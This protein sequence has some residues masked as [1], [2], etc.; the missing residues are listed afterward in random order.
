MKD[1][2]ITN[3]KLV[4]LARILIILVIV[5]IVAD[6][7]GIK[8]SRFLRSNIGMR[9]VTQPAGDLGA[10]ER[11][12]MEVFE[13]V[14]PSVTYITNK[15]FQRDYFSFNVMEIPQGTGSGFLWDDKGHIVTNFHVIYEA[16]EIEVRLQNGKSYDA[17]IVGADPDHDLAVL[18]IN[19]TNLNISPVMIGS[20]SD[21]RVGQKVLAIGNPFGLDSTLTTGIISALGRTIQSISNRYIHDVVQ[22]DAAINPGNSGGPLLDSFGRLIGVNTA[23]ISPSGT[24]SGVGF[25]VPVDTVNRIATKLI[26]YG[27][28]GRPGLGITLIPEHIMARLGIEG[29]GILEVLKGGSAEEAGLIEVKRLRNG[30]VE[31]GD[32]IT[33]CDGS[34]IKKSSDLVRIMDRHEVGDE[35]DIVIIRKNAKKT[36]R[37]TIQSVN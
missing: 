24:Y 25:A 36:V 30:R 27:K 31:M 26:N 15:R 7:L 28:V 22:T 37:I 9:P 17:T 5:W 2:S 29:V 13:Q 3:P 16:D 20:S 21:L 32:I 34:P 11:A 18:Q 14:S 23:I 10:D 6:F 4:K 1:N 33:E 19:T 35:V 12:N 8:P